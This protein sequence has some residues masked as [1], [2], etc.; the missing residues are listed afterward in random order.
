MTTVKILIIALTLSLVSAFGQIPAPSSDPCRKATT[1][2]ELNECMDRRFH[3]AESELQALYNRFLDQKEK[4]QRVAS[5]TEKTHA[6]E[7]LADLKAAQQAW[8]TYRDLQCRAESGLNAG[9]SIRPMM[10]SACL[11]SLTR[12]RIKQLHDT[13]D[14]Q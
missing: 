5:G 11:E 3:A 7:S 2:M 9:G 6:A 10:F 12:D 1:Q 8:I 14:P 13:Y 4:E